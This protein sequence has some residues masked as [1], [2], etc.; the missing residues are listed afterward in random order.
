M[1]EY[2]ECSLAT[3][4]SRVCYSPREL[5]YR[6]VCSLRCWRMVGGS[7]SWSGLRIVGGQDDSVRSDRTYSAA[8]NVH[9]V[10]VEMVEGSDRREWTGLKNG[11][12]LGE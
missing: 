7:L 9:M 10:M 6:K 12:S 5:D 1:A 2:V 8:R 11:N 4:S 3:F